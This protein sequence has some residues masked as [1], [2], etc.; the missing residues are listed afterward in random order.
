RHLYSR[1]RRGRAGIGRPRCRS[2]YWAD[3][4][5]L[6]WSAAAKRGSRPCARADPRNVTPGVAREL[7]E[8]MMDTKW[9]VVVIG[10][11]LGG[12]ATAGLLAR[13]GRRVLVLEQQAKPGGYAQ[14][15]RRNGFYFDISLR[16]MDGVA[17]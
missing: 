11:G 7:K 4:S 3:L 17:P 14:G 6:V 2:G 1:S 13:E 15:I 9:D 8:R 5:R 12:L 10:A 16:S